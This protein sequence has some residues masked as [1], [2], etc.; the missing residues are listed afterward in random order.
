VNISVYLDDQTAKKLTKL[1]KTQR[2]SRNSVIK[3]AIEDWIDHYDSEAWP[4]GFFDFEP[5]K[6]VPNFK[7]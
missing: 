2:R 5:I 1:A 7:S 6:D 3:E 4:K